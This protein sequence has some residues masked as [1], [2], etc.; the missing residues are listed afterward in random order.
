MTISTGHQES[1]MTMVMESCAL[2]CTQTMVRHSPEMPFCLIIDARLD[3][4][5][6]Q[7]ACDR[8]LE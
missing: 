4:G 1:Q 5:K 6:C 7:Y 3:C 2:I 8:F